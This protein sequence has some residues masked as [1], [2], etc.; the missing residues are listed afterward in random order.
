MAEPLIRQSPLS[1][2]QLAQAEHPRAALR[3]LQPGAQFVFRGDDAAYAAAS[4][5]L[6]VELPRQ[7]C[8]A[9]Q[10][11]SRAALWLGPDE[12]LLI[13]AEDDAATLHSSLAQALAPRPHALIPVGHRN[14]ALE[15]QGP[16]A[17]R[18]LSAGCPLDLEETAFPPGMCTR[19][20]IAK[21]P[22]IIWRTGGD[23]FYLNVWRSFAPYLWNYLVEARR[24]L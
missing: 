22:V 11:A 20:L 17:A 23:R 12:T 1:P 19:T 10:G 21:A 24:R 18:V 14:V 5:A 16:D 2:A 4:L 13:A 7:A 3:P 9:R 6:G 15:I 8:T